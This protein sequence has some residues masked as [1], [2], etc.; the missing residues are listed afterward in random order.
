MKYPSSLLLGT[1]LLLI[2]VIALSVGCIAQAPTAAGKTAASIGTANTN[3][4]RAVP[5]PYQDAELFSIGAESGKVLG[6]VLAQ[7]SDDASR[8]D[9]ASLETDSANLSSLAGDYYF[10]MK[11]LNVSPTYQ[12]WKKNYSLALLD[13]QTAGDY[14]YKSAV[15]AQSEDY[16]TALT[17]L[18]QG[19]TLFQRSNRYIK[20]AT[21]SIPQ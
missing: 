17:Y 5:P 18:E 3:L 10:Q 13:A 20:E 9:L 21:E 11:D 7:I 14:F 16:N 12:N 1:A 8:K 15:A 4:T 19:E 6:P 2:V